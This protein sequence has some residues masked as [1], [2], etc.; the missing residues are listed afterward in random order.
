MK[1][2]YFCCFF[3]ASFY[4]CTECLIEPRH[5]KTNV[6]VSDT[7]QAVQLQKMARGLKFRIN[8]EEGLYYQCSENKGADQLRGNREADLRLCFLICKMFVFSL[9]GSYGL[10]WSGTQKTD[11]LSARLKSELSIVV[12]AICF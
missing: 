5:E 1:V 6:L 9:R 3:L 11:F 7:N 8:E 2:D 12:M 10:V 4:G